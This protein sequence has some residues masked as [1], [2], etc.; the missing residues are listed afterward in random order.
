MEVNWAV[1]VLLLALAPLY[2]LVLSMF[3]YLGKIYAVRLMFWP[4]TRLQNQ[5]QEKEEEDERQEEEV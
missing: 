4:P 2:V 1:V 3:A 5:V